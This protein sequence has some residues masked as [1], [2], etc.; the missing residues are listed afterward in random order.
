MN[1]RRNVL[2]VCVLV[3]QMTLVMAS[4]QGLEKARLGDLAEIQLPSQAS[5]EESSTKLP[6]FS[7]YY[8]KR[9]DK[10]LLGIYVGNAPSVDQDKLRTEYDFGGCV[11]R[12]SEERAA[13]G[14][15]LDAVIKLRGAAFPKFVHF[16]SRGL[17][18]QEVAEVHQMWR[19]FRLLGD[20]RC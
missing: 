10:N 2:G 5:L 8:V 19:S 1:R 12:V 17:S 9:K 4:E 18:T 3:G 20:Q 6:D 16:F 13:N 15:S 7:L 11:G 14:T